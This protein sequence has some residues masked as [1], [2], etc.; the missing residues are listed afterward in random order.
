MKQ[1]LK[2]WYTKPRTSYIFELSAWILNNPSAFGIVYFM[3]LTVS[4]ILFTGLSI[5]FFI[6]GWLSA[7]V[8]I[9][10]FGAASLYKLFKLWQI[11]RKT[12]IL[13][14]FDTFAIKDIVGGAKNEYNRDIEK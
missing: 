10:V 4:S 14:A 2:Q 1:K 3:G 6:K 7:G 8:I 12:G 11:S 9:G 5:F 13:N